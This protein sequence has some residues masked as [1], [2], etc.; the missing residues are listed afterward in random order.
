MIKL[1]KPDLDPSE[2]FATC[3][4]RIRDADLRQRMLAVAVEIADASEAYDELAANGR[5]NEVLRDA[6]GGGSVT[7]AEME[8]VYTQRLAGKKGPGR[9]IYDTQISLAPQGKCPL[10]GQRSVST[11]DHHLPKAH[12]PTLSVTPVN[13]VPACS[14]CNK[15]KLAAMPEQPEDVALHP[16]YDDID[17]Q[18]WLQGVVLQAAP[19]AVSFSVMAPAAWDPVLSARVELHFQRLGLARLY[20]AE[21]ADELLNIRH[22][23]VRLHAIGGPN[24]VQHELAERADSCRQVRRNGWRTVTYDALA[25]SD[26]F[27]NGGFALT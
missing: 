11:L 24:L 20:A 9:P 2:V 12:Y 1:T 4:S 15:A 17:A 6:P 3:I 13:L 27:C 21:A 7:T 8:A 23:L 25:V 22:Q 18:Q 19:A 5:L 16:Y 14:D 10:C 26:W